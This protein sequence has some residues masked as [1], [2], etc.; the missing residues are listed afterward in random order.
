MSG[1]RAA[2]LALPLAVEQDHFGAPS[3]RVNGKI[4]AQLSA[5]GLTGLVKLPLGTQAWA[6]AEH[7]DAC[8]KEPRWGRHGW[9][10]L[11]WASLPPALVTDLLTS[12]WRCVTPAR[13]H[14]M[15]DGS[16]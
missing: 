13:L 14:G 7:P 12:S 4:F 6:V 3:F 10:R 11:L 5:D 2:A 16:A 15:L 1:F 9:T 8:S